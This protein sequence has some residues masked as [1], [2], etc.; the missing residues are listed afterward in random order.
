MLGY[1]EEFRAKNPNNMMALSIMASVY[2]KRGDRDT[3]RQLLEQGLEQDAKWVNGYTALA[4]N[5]VLQ[6][7]PEAAVG[8][9]ERGLKALPESSLLKILL[10][11]AHEKLD[12]KDRAVQLYEEV[13]KA[14]PDHQA[15]INNLASLLT[16]EYASDRK[17]S[18]V[19]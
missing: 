16:D 8:S 12:N 3:A 1:L 6:G 9:L 19:R 4:A 5:N 18:V 13:L 14:N 15:V 17:Y 11:S 7:D 10:A 2:S